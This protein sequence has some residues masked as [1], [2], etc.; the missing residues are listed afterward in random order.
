MHRAHNPA[1]KLA[2][3]MAEEGITETKLAAHLGVGQPI[4][5]KWKRG[6]AVP[7]TRILFKLRALT[8]G[9]V[10]F[11]DFLPAAS[12]AGGQDAA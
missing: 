3:Y 7:S 10:S 9:A 8:K 6:K 4:V 11:D 1:M 12:A 2:E 5:N